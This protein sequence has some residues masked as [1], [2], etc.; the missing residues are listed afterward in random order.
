MDRGAW[1][2]TVRRVAKSGTRLKR[3]SIQA[4][5]NARGWFRSQA[6]W[7]RG[8][9][10]GPAPSSGPPLPRSSPPPP[11]P[12]LKTLCFSLVLS[13]TRSP[14]TAGAVAWTAPGCVCRS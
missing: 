10:S 4:R 5:W 2:E 7:V 9:I 14:T 11:P 13:P 1:G 8:G 3:L 6:P 12:A